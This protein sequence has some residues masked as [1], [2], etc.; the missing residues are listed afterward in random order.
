MVDD[1]VRQLKIK[2]DNGCAISQCNLAAAFLNGFGC[3]IDVVTGIKYY[4][5]AAQQGSMRAES[6]LDI[7]ERVLL[8]ANLD[9]VELGTVN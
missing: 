2:A 6:A 7:I 1:K 5:L 8:D 4:R 3:R 9:S